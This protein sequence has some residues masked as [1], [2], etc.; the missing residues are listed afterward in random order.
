MEKEK[1]SKQETLALR[2]KHIGPSCKLFFKSDPLK[3]VRALGSYM[4]DEEGNRYLDCINNVCHVG[5]CHPH[6]VSAATQQMAV[7]NTN[8]RFLHDN[9]VIYAERLTAL[10]PPKL[11]VCFFVN[12]GSEA[13]DLALRLARTHTG[14]R[15]VITLDHAYHG[16]VT[17]LI[18]ISPY[19]FNHPGGD[20]KPDWVHVAP[21]ADIY[22]GKYTDKDYTIEQLSEK[23]A[24]EVKMLCQKSSKEGGQVCIFFAES[25]QSCG[26]QIVFPPGYLRQVYKHVREA[27]GVCLADEVQVGFG[28]VGSHMW[29]FQTQGDDV[30]PDI[31]TLGK[32]M[33][34]GHPVSAVITTREIAE[35]FGATGMEY[36]NT[37]GGNPVSAAVA[38]AVLD[39]IEN[40]KLRDNA[41]KIGNFL[42]QEFRQLQ[43]RYELIGDVRGQGMFLGVDLVKDRETRE[44][45]TA[46]AAYINKRLK[47]NYVLLSADGPYRNVLKFKSPLVFS[48][49]DAKELVSKVDSIMEEM[50]QVEHCVN[51]VV[52]ENSATEKSSSKS[53]RI[54]NG[55]QNE[56]QVTV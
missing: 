11:S 1:L 12:S 8:S 2:K 26:G 56:I 7:L 52:K 30:V 28:R 45:A 47:E 25:M 49:E 15:D 27:G 3:I 17:S 42:M 35:S 23:Y 44:P 51:G 43:K 53:K 22:R 4:Y 41:T 16:H 48:L 34:N 9:L 33:G 46:E 6:V 20:G 24:D 54:P 29:A 36:F 14:H 18:D 37:F 21:V 55:S 39:V 32:P 40:E 50:K 38:N 19:K 10:F 5:H 31:V 13:N